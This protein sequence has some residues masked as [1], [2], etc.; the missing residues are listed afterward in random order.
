[1][2]S[3]N[4]IGVSHDGV[5]QIMIEPCIFVRF[6]PVR[7]THNYKF[8]SCVFTVIGWV[9]MEIRVFHEAAAFI[10][11]L[12]AKGDFIHRRVNFKNQ[13]GRPVSTQ[14]FLPVTLVPHGRQNTEMLDVKCAANIPIQNFPDKFSVITDDVEV[15]CRICENS[16]LRRTFTLLMGREADAVK[17]KRFGV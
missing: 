7:Q 14:N 11:S 8:V 3:R 2:E 5:L 16:C 6:Q 15:I 17:L 9:N 13:W 4:L 1:M 12:S 10:K